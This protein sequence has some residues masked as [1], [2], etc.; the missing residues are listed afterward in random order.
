M[1]I[2]KTHEPCQV[3]HIRGSDQRTM[4]ELPEEMEDVNL[5]QLE[6]SA[7]DHRTTM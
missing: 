1:L 6:C 7:H 4:K 5:S 2:E 3:V